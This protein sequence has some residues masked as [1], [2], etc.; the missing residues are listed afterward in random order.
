M[1]KQ[2][3]LSKRAILLKATRDCFIVDVIRAV[4]RQ[5]ITLRDAGILLDHVNCDQKEI[6][7]VT[8]ELFG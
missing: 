4:H 5:E 2:P 6:D 3:S 7:K 1:K 8:K